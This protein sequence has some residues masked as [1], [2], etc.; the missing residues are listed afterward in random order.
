MNNDIKIYFDDRI[1]V[2]TDKNIKSLS[3][4]N[5]QVY[6]F[7]NKKNLAKELSR[8]ESSDDECL[9]IIHSDINELFEYTASCFR[10]IEAAGGLV[11]LTDSRILF[12]R[13]LGKWDLP[14]G[15]AEKNESLQETALRE[16]MEECGLDHRLRIARELTNTYHTYYRKGNHILKRTA[17]FA[18]EYD[19]EDD[20]L[21]PQTSEDITDAV[22]LPES[23]LD[24]VL[25]NTY[26]SVIHVVGEWMKREH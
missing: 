1:V 12:I 4:D 9:C 21:V 5:H 15:K 25:Q 11:T 23:Q 20:H 18:M 7:E 22:W 26:K 8:F 6:V 3:T 10:F 24:I 19:G 13:R 16:V 2:L 17:W 14:K